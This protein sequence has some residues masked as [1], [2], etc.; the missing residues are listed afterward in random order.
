MCFVV[1]Q[2]CGLLVDKVLNV[3]MF[4]LKKVVGIVKKVVLLVIVNVEYNEGVDIDEF[5]IKSIYVDKV[6]LFKC[7][8]VCVKGCGNCIEK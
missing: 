7:F 8:I 1:D 4:L 2:I 6:V 3:L 5:K